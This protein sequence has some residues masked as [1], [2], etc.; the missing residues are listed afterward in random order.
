MKVVISIGGSL[1]TRELSY[2]N[3]KKYADVINK[4]SKNIKLSLFVV[5]VQQQELIR[6]SLEKLKQA[7]KC[8]I[9]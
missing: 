7:M 1:L 4:I 2:E 5:V 6:V 9:L 3:F 8:L